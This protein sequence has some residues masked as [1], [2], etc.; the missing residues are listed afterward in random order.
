ME[1]YVAAICVCG[2]RGERGLFHSL[3][4]FYVAEIKC[5]TLLARDNVNMYHKVPYE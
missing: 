5:L 3:V 1:A 4:W 2:G